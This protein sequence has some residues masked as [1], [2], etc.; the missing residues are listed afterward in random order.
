VNELGAPQFAPWTLKAFFPSAHKQSASNQRTS[1][2]DP[3]VADAKDVLTSR[4]A[5]DHKDDADA[6]ASAKPMAAPDAKDLALDEDMKEYAR[7]EMLQQVASGQFQS[8]MEAEAAFLYDWSRLRADDLLS[9]VDAK[10]R[11]AMRDVL[12]AHFA[13]LNAAYRHYATGSSET[14]YGMNGPELAHLCHESGLAELGSP[15]DQ[16]VVVKAVSKTLRLRD[17]AL[18]SPVDGG[19]TL[20]RAGF[21]HALL[22]VLMTGSS[23]AVEAK[24]KDKVAPAV[25]R[26]T[27]GPL[28]DLT[29]DDVR[30]A[31]V[32]MRWILLGG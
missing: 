17:P 16:E 31:M 2:R 12:L 21:L 18:T 25:A 30:R 6:K 13:P 27:S 15:N 29:H 3:L 10:A 23:E 26:L 19:A 1:P 8:E 28:R 32:L 22:R 11:D 7:S 14:G 24:L 4:S 20:S 9:A 5:S